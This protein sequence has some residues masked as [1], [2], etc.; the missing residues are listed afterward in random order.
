MATRK[1]PS[2]AAAAKAEVEENPEKK[3]VEWQGLTLEL[4][5]RPP[6]SLLFR[7]I[8][9]EDSDGPQPMLKM[10]KRMI[11]DDQFESVVRVI[12]TADD[13][14]E[15]IASAFGLVGE[16]FAQYGVDEGE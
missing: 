7:S 16:I 4:P 1:K 9:A 14:D 13:E 3:S 12:E 11:G 5:D 15:V 8:Q 10:L 2:K 6:Q